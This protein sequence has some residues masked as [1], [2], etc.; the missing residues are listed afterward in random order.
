MT[1][2]ETTKA[3]QYRLEKR[4]GRPLHPGELPSLSAR[5]DAAGIWRISVILHYIL[6]DR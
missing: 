2:T 4:L 3:A 6:R 1:R 5:R